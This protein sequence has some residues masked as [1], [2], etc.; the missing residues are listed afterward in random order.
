MR[1]VGPLYMGC[2]L[3]VHL[4]VADREVPHTVHYASLQH[5]A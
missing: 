1:Y 4:H 2:V 5:D 3:L